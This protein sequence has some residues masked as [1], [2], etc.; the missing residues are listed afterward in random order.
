MWDQTAFRQTRRHSRA[1]FVLH[2]PQRTD[3]LRRDILDGSPR[4]QCP[5][6]AKLVKVPVRD[7][8]SRFHVRECYGQGE[9]DKMQKSIHRRDP[10]SERRSTRVPAVV[11]SSRTCPEQPQCLPVFQYAGFVACA[12]QGTIDCRF[13]RSQPVSLRTRISLW[14]R[15]DHACCGNDSETRMR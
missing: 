6:Y 15:R 13:A 14:D 4:L 1:R 8:F 9:R 12:A 10:A 11:L 2:S 5:V 3:A 7:W